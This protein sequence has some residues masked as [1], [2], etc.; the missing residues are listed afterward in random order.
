M[1]KYAGD[2]VAAQAAGY[3]EAV[4]N[5]YA[6]TK[7]STRFSTRQLQILDIQLTGVAT[8]PYAPNS[9]Y[10]K[11]VRGIQTVAELQIVGEPSADHFTVVVAY[12]TLNDG[13]NTQIGVEQGTDYNDSGYTQGPND[14]TGLPNGNLQFSPEHNPNAQEIQQAINA[15]TGGSSNVTYKIFHGAGLRSASQMYS[16]ESIWQDC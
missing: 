10:S 3:T 4:T 9:L 6:R 2:Q 13:N 11:A 8:N 7:P 15:A 14:Q 1:A 5:N 16:D 12:D